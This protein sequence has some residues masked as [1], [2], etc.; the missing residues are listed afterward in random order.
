MA[1]LLAGWAA[2]F[3]GV[4]DF[5][6]GFAARK[7]PLLPT[8]ILGQ[9]VGG[10]VALAALLT[11]A[12]GQPVPRDLLW[13]ALAGLTGTLGM[14][15]LYGGLARS[16][17][18]IVSPTSAMVG[19]VLP[20]LFGLCL[21]ERPQAMAVTGSLLCLPAILLLTWEG[22]D[23]RHDRQ[24]SRAALGY[25][26]LAGLG[27]GCFFICISRAH[28]GSGVWPLLGA[29]TASF[30]A[31]LIALRVTGREFRLTRASLLPAVLS[32]STDMAANVMYLVATQKGMLSLVTV[33]TSL[34][35][36]PTVILARIFM[37]QKLPPVRLAGLALALTGVGLISFR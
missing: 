33:I 13:G 30:T 32:G 14:F 1:F 24:E 20:V 10:L 11:V 3:Y 25:G 26:V 5:C 37:H 29:R 2:L 9:L 23:A 35:P 21:G 22:G 31:C 6:G 8:L 15:T 7:A 17:V 16:I 36:A 12:G 27:F 18:A 28:A 4:A 19:T 34:Y